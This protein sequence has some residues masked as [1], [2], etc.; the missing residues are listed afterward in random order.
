MSSS[1]E[2][3]QQDCDVSLFRVCFLPETISTLVLLAAVIA[4]LLLCSLAMV[5]FTVRGDSS[6]FR[7]QRQ[8]AQLTLP[9]PLDYPDLPPISPWELS[10]EASVVQHNEFEMAPVTAFAQA[11][12]DSSF[13]ISSS[14]T[15]EPEPVTETETITLPFEAPQNSEADVSEHAQ[16]AMAQSVHELDDPCL[17]DVY[18]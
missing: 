1:Q 12:A 2:T 9:P 14:P 6:L 16:D 5:W 3:G 15:V 8:Q 13:S 10:A 7:Q 4:V 17:T 11:D 18:L